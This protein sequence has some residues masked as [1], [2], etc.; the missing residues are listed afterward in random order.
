MAA[1]S[2]DKEGCKKVFQ[3]KKYSVIEISFEDL[4]NFTAYSRC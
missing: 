1:N 2:N 4:N 3:I